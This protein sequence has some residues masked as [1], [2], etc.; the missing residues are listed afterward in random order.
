MAPFT[1]EVLLFGLVFTTGDEDG[2]IVEETAVTATR[3]TLKLVDTSDPLP[4]TTSI[5]LLL[6]TLT[7]FASVCK[8]QNFSLVGLL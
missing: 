3:W 2:A 7:S 4:A 6:D 1:T 8:K 5:K